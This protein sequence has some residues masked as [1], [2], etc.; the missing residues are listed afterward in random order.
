MSDPVLEHRL[1]VDAVLLGQKLQEGSLVLT[2]GEL[3]FET[4][5]KRFLGNTRVTKMLLTA[6]QVTGVN[7]LDDDVAALLLPRAA[8]SR[9]QGNQLVRVAGSVR[10]KPKHGQQ[11]STVDAAYD[12]LVGSHSVP[13]LVQRVRAWL[14]ASSSSRRPSEPATPPAQVCVADAAEPELVGRAGDGPTGL[15][16]H[17]DL[18]PVADMGVDSER[19]RDAGGEAQHGQR[20]LSASKVLSAADADLVSSALPSRF[21]QSSWRL[22]YST[23][24][25][26]ISLQTFYARLGRAKSASVL[27]LRDTADRV[28]GCF[29][30]DVWRPVV[31]PLVYY[32]SAETFVFSLRPAAFEV[33]RWRPGRNSYFQLSTSQWIC[34][35]GPSYALYVDSDFLHGTTASCDTFASPPLAASAAAAC[36][37]GQP[38]ESVSFECVELEVWGVQPYK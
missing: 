34:C 28:F 18:E 26:G 7:V 36:A 9:L 3:A 33:H 20:L 22:L 1:S 21:Q 8:A 37:S 13:E 5:S 35:G 10:A 14:D 31:K 27:V 12:L 15:S 24:R 17:S 32:G 4:I 2:P 23:S 6:E 38:A 25:D 30:V 16:L 11:H 29:T 19:G